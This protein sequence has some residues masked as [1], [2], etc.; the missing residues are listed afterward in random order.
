MY[1]WNG[2]YSA[3][4]KQI[5]NTVFIKISRQLREDDRQIS[6]REDILVVILHSPSFELVTRTRL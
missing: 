1:S 6:L 3:I 4:L 2:I 5:I